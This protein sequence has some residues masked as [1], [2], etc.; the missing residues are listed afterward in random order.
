MADI[1][2]SVPEWSTLKQRGIRA[3]G[4]CVKAK[5]KC[6]PNPHQK[7]KCQRCQRLDKE[8]EPAASTHRKRPQPQHVVQLER[9]L[10]ALVDLLNSSKGQGEVDQVQNSIS[11][12][13]LHRSPTSVDQLHQASSFI[14]ARTCH[15][16]RLGSPQHATGITLSI[17]PQHTPRTNGSHF[18]LPNQEGAF[19]LLEFRT[20]MARQFPFVVIPPNATSESLR[21]ERPILWKAILTAASCLKPSRQEAMGQELIEEFSTRLLLNGEKSLDLL[22]ALLI[23]IAWSHYH[24]IINPQIV[25]LM[26]LAKSLVANLSLQGKMWWLNVK[27][28]RLDQIE[29]T[30]GASKQIRDASPL[31]L[32]SKH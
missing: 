12:F 16:T 31:E 2:L 5:V 26:G 28:R 20:S 6:V 3:C 9:K 18:D 19:L 8:C 15:Q 1:S 11:G 24:S 4:T 27:G 13:V 32:N 10:D 23:H 14:E 7:Q 29:K 22:Q 30:D 17:E 21:T 25:N